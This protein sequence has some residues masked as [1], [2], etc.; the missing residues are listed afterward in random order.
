MPTVTNN[1][2]TPHAKQYYIYRFDVLK[3]TLADTQMC[4]VAGADSDILLEEWPDVVTL[5]DDLTNHKLYMGISL[6]LS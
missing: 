3:P 6:L 2:H 5:Q 1:P 4:F